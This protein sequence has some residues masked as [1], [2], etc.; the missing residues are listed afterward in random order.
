M[1]DFESMED[2]PLPDEVTAVA[3][4]EQEG[5]NPKADAE[6]A[7]A[8]A[9]DEAKT[10]S[11]DED[12]ADADDTDDAEADDAEAKETKSQRKRRLRRE[13]EQ[14]R[15]SE[16]AR[17]NERIAHLEQRLGALNE[18]KYED[19]SNPDDYIAE[20]S[21]YAARRANLEDEAERARQEAGHA[22][23]NAESAKSEARMDLI[24]EG[25]E[26]HPDFVD[27][28]GKI[29]L[30]EQ[31]LGAAME[32][33]N[34]T[35]VLYFL[36]KNPTEAARIASMSPV[37]Q[38]VE[39]GRISTTLATPKPKRQTSAPPPVKPLRGAS[40]KF[41]KSPEDMSYEEYKRWRSGGS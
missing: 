24:K 33:D 40:G 17:A 20:R 9:E 4:S 31:T 37:G 5:E 7:E 38:A 25:Q 22:Q 18:P 32:A 34:S 27:V 3:T 26:A 16:L 2:A 13:R 28:V 12:D 36:G 15:E 11:S 1:S 39:I 21:G 14:E 35:D 23:R 6:D 29:P 10:K 41:E 30:T 19:F 8:D